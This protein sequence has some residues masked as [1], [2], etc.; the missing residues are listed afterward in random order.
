MASPSH[1]AT[2]SRT[3]TAAKSSPSHSHS[4]TR[5]RSATR[6]QSADAA[7]AG[8]VGDGEEALQ[9]QH[10]LDERE[11]AGADSADAAHVP[12]ELEGGDMV[13][14]APPVELE[15]AAEG[16]LNNVEDGIGAGHGG[17]A[18]PEGDI[19]S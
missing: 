13:E 16:E 5:T 9:Q 1:S 10:I 17:A 12:L 3:S 15:N 6:S 2:R 7:A 14:A 4:P 8:A 19:D 11:V 18:G